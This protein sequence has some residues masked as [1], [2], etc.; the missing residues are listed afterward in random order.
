MTKQQWAAVETQIQSVMA[1]YHA[2]RLESLV[3]LKPRT[4]LLRKNP[5]MFL[6]KNLT[7]A[8]KFAR[9]ILEA[10]ASS[11]EETLFGQLLEDLAIFVSGMLD[12]G[13]K[14]TTTGLDLEFTRD[15]QRF[16]VAIKSSKN[17]GN[18]GQ[19]KNLELNFT[20]AKKVA[21]QSK[22]SKPAIAV[23]GICY[24]NAKN[25]DKGNYLFFIGQGFWNFIS[26]V[27][28]FYK[29]IIVPLSHEAEKHDIQ[30]QVEWDKAV[31]RFSKYILDDFCDNSGV[32][33]WEKFVEFNSKNL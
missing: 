6:C 12:N 31:N 25:E 15:G 3:E 32:I 10:H 30:Y 2:K 27:P 22:L 5:Y 21:A 17:W 7:T 8:D 33:N 20:T 11:S 23:L 26:G 9:L 1:N 28:S 24:G 18:S 13:Y 14:S 16:L 4:I 29:D 19:H